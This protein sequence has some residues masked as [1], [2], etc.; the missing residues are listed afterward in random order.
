MKRHRFLPWLLLGGFLVIAGVLW[1]PL[2]T[3][4]EKPQ[5]WRPA[6]RVE[7]LA[8][9][10]SIRNQLTAFRNDDYK[11]AVKYQSSGLQRNFPSIQAFR[12]MM[13]RN[14]PQFTNYQSANFG[15]AQTDRSGK[16]LKIPIELIGHDK[17]KVRALYMLVLEKQ[18]FRVA[19]VLGGVPMPKPPSRALP[20]PPQPAQPQQAPGIEL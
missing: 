20:A 18:I 12:T 13:R 10:R 16:F 6:T 3:P 1:W 4:P 7:R 11:T 14:Y 19:G 5:Q 2:P 17:V 15:V 9:I 8:A